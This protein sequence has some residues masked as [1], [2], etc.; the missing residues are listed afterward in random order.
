M[1]NSGIVTTDPLF[2]GLTRPTM[3]LGVS[4]PFAILNGLTTLITYINSPGIK[5]ILIAVAVHLFAYIVCFKEPL[6]LELFLKKGEKTSKCQNKFY[7]GANS[8]DP[9]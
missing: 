3:F 1:A 2:V 4:F 7:H 5:V 8:Y 9:F 6:F